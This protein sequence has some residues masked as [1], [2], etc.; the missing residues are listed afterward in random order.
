MQSVMKLFMLIH[1]PQK[2]V[3][4][5]AN[6][7]DIGIDEKKIDFGDKTV[8]ECLN[9]IYT[10]VSTIPDKQRGEFTSAERIIIINK[11]L[12][13][14]RY[15]PEDTEYGMSKLMRMRLINDAYPLHDG[16]NNFVGKDMEFAN[17]RQVLRCCSAIGQTLAYAVLFVNLWRRK[18]SELKLR[19]NVEYK[20]I[21]SEPSQ[22]KEEI[23][24]C[25][26]MVRLAC[27][28][29]FSKSTFR[30]DQRNQDLPQY[31]VEYRLEPISRY[32]LTDEL[33]EMVWK[34]DAKLSLCIEGTIVREEIRISQPDL[35]LEGR[36][37]PPLA[38]PL[39]LDCMVTTDAYK[40]VAAYRR[41][42]PRKTDG[43]G[44]WNGILLGVTYLS[45]ATNALAMAF[46]SDFVGRE[47]YR[48]RFN[49]LRGFVN[50]T[51]SGNRVDEFCQH[52]LIII[53]V[54]FAADDY[55]LYERLKQ[56]VSVC[57]YRGM[58]YP[59]DHP[60]RYQLNSNYWTELTWKL[61]AIIIFEHII[62]LCSGILNYA[63]PNISTSVE[64]QLDMDRILTREAKLKLL[65]AE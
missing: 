49:G 7:Y 19:W 43:I 59:P 41:P 37:P 55:Y 61:I 34:S 21:G 4:H 11:I 39:G 15:G 27:K 38:T 20:D 65:N 2:I 53:F 28:K 29:R 40:Y 8:S 51:L 25:R 5:N 47:V 50:Y 63:I 12:E 56:N 42:V 18:E 54:E 26:L 13:S 24:L 57:Y 17:D 62:F 32:Q 22:N 45:T 16:P 9:F 30:G 60:Q 35:R 46:T 1:I 6:L 23:T 48:A 58:R 52:L 14:T 44:S 31:E 10:P 33:C 64:Q 36:A 3:Q